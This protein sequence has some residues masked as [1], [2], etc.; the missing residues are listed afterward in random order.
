MAMDATA[1]ATA[2][3]NSPLTQQFRPLDPTTFVLQLFWLTLTFGLL[4]VLLKLIGLPRVGGVIEERRKRIARDLDRAVKLRTKTQLALSN[5]DQAL[6]EAH[7]TA[8]A[9]AREMRD[10]L[11][12]AFQSERAGMER[13]LSQNLAEAELRIVKSK[14]RAMAS[15]D[16][17][18]AG[19][20]TAIVIRLI[21][22]EVSMDEVQR[23]PIQR[24]AKQSV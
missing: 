20:A 22:G 2:P 9:V 14:A 17:I 10:Q 8:S 4:Y 18:A 23:A 16:D 1:I 11:A 15:L 13:Q 5:Y 21:G 19:T 12:A 3:S 6:V 24:A 7:T